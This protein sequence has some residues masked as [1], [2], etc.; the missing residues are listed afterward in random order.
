M[1]RKFVLT[2]F[3]A[4]GKSAVGAMVARRLGWRLVDSDREIEL[5]AGKSIVTIFA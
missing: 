5:R 1:V 3:M 4:T 2:G